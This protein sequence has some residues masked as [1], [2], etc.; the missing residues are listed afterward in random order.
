MN[1][2]DA[3]KVRLLAIDDNSDSAELIARIATK[4]G[5]E[6]RSMSD[7][8]TV[9]QV[10]EQWKPHVLTLDLCMPQEDGIGMLSTLKEGGFAGSLIIVSGQ[11]DW[12][13]RAAGR[14]ASARGLNVADDLSKPIDI[15][16]LR[17]LLTKLQTSFGA[18]ERSG[19]GSQKASA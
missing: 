13:R 9:R 6:A 8:R 16:T 14:L 1:P 5:Y 10:L 11:D 15:K 7:L 2:P 17:D 12:L 4:C 3:A 18:S 19:D